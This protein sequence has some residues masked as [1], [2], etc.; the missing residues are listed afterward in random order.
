MKGLALAGLLGLLCFLWIFSP[1]LDNH[2][3]ADDWFFLSVVSRVQSLPQVLNFFTFDTDWF[4]RPVQWLMTY[5]LYQSFGE[6]PVPYHLVS[7]ALTLVNAILLAFIAY[8]LLAVSPNSSKAVSRTL[9]IVTGI[10]FTFSA[11]HH[12]AVFWFS[13]INELL[14]TLFK[15]AAIL[16]VLCAVRTTGRPTWL[17][18]LLA[19][20]AGSLALLSKESA[21]T[22]PLELLLIL[23][24]TGLERPGK[25]NWSRYVAILAPFLGITFLW[26]GLYLA[27]ARAGSLASLGHGGL[28]FQQGTFLDFVFKY[29][30]FFNH[31]YIQADFVFGSVY[32][33]LLELLALF[34]LA[35]VAFLRQRY[36]WLLAFAWTIVALG[37]YIAIE[38]SR[39]LN[40]Q[41]LK[42]GGIPDR[43]LYYSAA[44][45]SLLLVV[46]GQWLLDEMNRI[47][48]KAYI[49]ALTTAVL[50]ILVVLFLIFNVTSLVEAEGEWDTAGKIYTSLV[51]DLA[52]LRARA[53]ENNALCIEKLPKT[54]KGKYVFGGYVPG[55]MQLVYEKKVFEVLASPNTK[56]T[57]FDRKQ[58]SMLLEYDT[59][60]NT[61]IPRR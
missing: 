61:L 33:V 60:T 44:G 15:F 18:Y 2:F 22:L 30:Y 59:A 34:L 35:G 25:L 47:K 17:L 43:Y 54:Y 51:H 12:E 58:C 9:A 45:A 14:V 20:G 11:P 36:L 26:L 1:G 28:N 55:V 50:V 32:S 38:T 13:S 42:L 56:E 31:H 40:W 39:V 8:T 46:S 52:G 6:N 48:V 29:L 23:L 53:G 3:V 16:L 37:P 49:P 41:N 4:V 5:G 21:M 27:G 7:L 57:A 19:L 24:Y 10:L